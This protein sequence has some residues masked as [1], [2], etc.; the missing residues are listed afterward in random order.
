M[1]ILLELDD[2]EVDKLEETVH[3]YQD[4]GPWPNGWSSSLLDVVRNK[5]DRAIKD[6]KSNNRTKP[7]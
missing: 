5:I 7:T 3:G 4:E 1:K 6:A 2:K